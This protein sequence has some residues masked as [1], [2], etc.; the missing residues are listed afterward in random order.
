[1]AEAVGAG[2]GGG[3]GEVG[4][5]AGGEREKGKEEAD[6]S[7]GKLDPGKGDDSLGKGGGIAR[8]TSLG[9]TV[10]SVAVAGAGGGAAAAPGGGGQGAGEGE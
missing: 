2:G 7:R 6:N 3:G 4:V 5:E 10:L 8:P 1:M 9:G